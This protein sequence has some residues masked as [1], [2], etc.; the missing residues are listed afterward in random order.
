MNSPAPIRVQV[1]LPEDEA[2]AL[3]GAGVAPR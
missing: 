3:A 2:W 1:E